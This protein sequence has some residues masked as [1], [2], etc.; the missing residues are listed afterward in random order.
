VECKKGRAIATKRE[1]TRHLNSFLETMQSQIFEAQRALLNK[2]K[3]ITV[4]SIRNKMLGI[5]E[6]VVDPLKDK[7]LMQVYREHIKH[8]SDLVGKEYAQG[9]LKRFRA[10]FSSLEAYMQHKKIDDIK[11][12]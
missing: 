2:G 5:E 3:E 1:E 11:L 7:S 10:A 4:K 8:V 9:T 6:E 12:R